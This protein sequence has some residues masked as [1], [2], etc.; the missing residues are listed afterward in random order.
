M[1]PLGYFAC[2]DSA[3][4]WLFPA[5]L[6]ATSME[7]ILHHSQVDKGCPYRSFVDNWVLLVLSSDNRQLSLEL[8]VFSSCENQHCGVSGCG[9]WNELFPWGRQFF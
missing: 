7:R 2:V 3:G 9:F 6:L 4:L 8:S 5:T 1:Q